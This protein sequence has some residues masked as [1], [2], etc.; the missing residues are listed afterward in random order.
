M[1]AASRKQTPPDAL[2]SHGFHLRSFT[3]K[4]L[5]WLQRQLPKKER[6]SQREIIERLVEAEKARVESA[7]GRRCPYG[8]NV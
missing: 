6:E 5:Q 1:V 7:M 3:I 4:T 8:P 2:V